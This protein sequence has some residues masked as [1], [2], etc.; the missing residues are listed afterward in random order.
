M[1]Q[2]VSTQLI[3]SL[4]IHSLR[5]NGTM[6]IFSCV[7]AISEL[8]LHGNASC[9]EGIISSHSKQVSVSA[10]S[11]VL[12]ALNDFMIITSALS[13]RFHNSHIGLYDQLST[14]RPD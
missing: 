10:F 8:S 13:P 2:L 9:F 14:I 6:D 7:I 12:E 3:K 4:S 5:L 11:S 1:V